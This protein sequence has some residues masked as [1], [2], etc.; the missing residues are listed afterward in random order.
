MYRKRTFKTKCKLCK[1]YKM[2][3][4]GFSYCF[5]CWKKSNDKDPAPP[6]RDFEE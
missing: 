1:K 5:D 2:M 6:R 4:E 3:R